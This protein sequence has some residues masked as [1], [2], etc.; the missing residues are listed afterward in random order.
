MASWLMPVMFPNR[1][2]VSDGVSWP[3]SWLEGVERVWQMERVWQIEMGW[4]WQMERAW[5]VLIQMVEG[6]EEDTV[7]L[8]G[9]WTKSRIFS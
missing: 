6:E 2:G 8:C 5:L 4:V 1:V 3:F 9:S 7:F